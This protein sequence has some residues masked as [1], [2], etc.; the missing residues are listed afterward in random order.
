MATRLRTSRD[1]EPQHLARVGRRSLVRHIDRAV[2]PEGNARGKRQAIEQHFP[3][4]ARTLAHQS[5]H[6]EAGIGRRERRHLTAR[7]IAFAPNGELFVVEMGVGGPRGLLRPEA[8][9]STDCAF[10]YVAS[11][12]LTALALPGRRSLP[13][14]APTRSSRA[15]GR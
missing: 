6:A 12:R 7:D 14:P 8:I 10:A 1:R 15:A 13:T 9:V 4:S 11:A 5:A 3:R 2:R